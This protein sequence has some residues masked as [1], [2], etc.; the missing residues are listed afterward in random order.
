[1]G[2]P[3]GRQRE[4]TLQPFDGKELYRGLGSGF[5]QWGRAFV[6]QVGFSERACG[7]V[8]PEDIKVDVFG[9]HLAGTAQK[10]YRRQVGNW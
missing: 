2:V 8:W 4:L 6:R 7:F 3:D 10:Y 1:M 5:L 9:Q